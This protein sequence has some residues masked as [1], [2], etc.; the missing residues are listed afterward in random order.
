VKRLNVRNPQRSVCCGLEV[1]FSVEL[2]NQKFSRPKLKLN[3]SDWGVLKRQ[4]GLR[5]ESNSKTTMNVPQK[6]Q[7]AAKFPN[8]FFPGV[9]SFH[10]ISMISW[11]AICGGISVA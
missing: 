10:Q 3:D 5:K 9:F 8:C 4:Q 6:S 2:P 11:L 7:E 1:Y